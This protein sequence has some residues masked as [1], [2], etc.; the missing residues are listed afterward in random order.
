[1]TIMV[2]YN[3][4]DMIFGHIFHKPPRKMAMYPGF[5]DVSIK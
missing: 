5:M 2:S 4:A 3:V 1:M